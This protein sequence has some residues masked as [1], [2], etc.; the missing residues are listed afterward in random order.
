MVWNVNDSSRRYQQQVQ[1]QGL[2]QFQ[3]FH[4]HNRQRAD[5][6]MND[7]MAG[8]HARRANE[9]EQAPGRHQPD[10]VS[11]Q[12]E[13]GV[14]QFRGRTNTTLAVSVLIVAIMLVV[15]AVA[16]AAGY[17]TFSGGGPV[18]AGGGGGG[19][20]SSAVAGS[21]PTG[22][23]VTGSVLTGSNVRQG[24]GTSFGVVAVLASGSDVTVSCVDAGWA[25]LASPYPG[26]YIFRGLLALNQDPKPCTEGSA[27]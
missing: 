18:L 21:A 14:P 27:R 9:R 3:R 1:Q 20:Q 16:A 2:Q 19:A 17:R 23:D 26:S 8:W 5:K 15:I 25:R 10:G 24:P 7:L 13:H 12:P 22:S 4:R 6:Q 11:G